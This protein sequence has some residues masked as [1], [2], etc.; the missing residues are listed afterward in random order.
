[1][2]SIKQAMVDAI[3][4]HGH[5]LQGPGGIAAAAPDL[6]DHIITAA[7]EAQGKALETSV[8]KQLQDAL[9]AANDRVAELGTQNEELGTRI[10]DLTNRLQQLEFKTTPILP[11]V[12][13]VEQHADD[14]PPTAA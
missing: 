6:V 10:H 11:Q 9:D 12:S 4:A 1:M 3:V 14:S 8:T 2:D 13:S 5:L 7:Q